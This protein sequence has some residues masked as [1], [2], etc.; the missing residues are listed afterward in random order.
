MAEFGEAHGGTGPEAWN[1][2]AVC[3]TVVPGTDRLSAWPHG[4]GWK[5]R[6]IAY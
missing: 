5:T 3:H 1:A 4:F 2:C 6:S